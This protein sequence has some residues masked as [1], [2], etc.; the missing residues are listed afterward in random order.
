VTSEAD[1]VESV[2]IDLREGQ[3]RGVVGS[4]H[5]FTP[6]GSFFCPSLEIGHDDEGGLDISFDQAGFTRFVDACFG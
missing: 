2:A 5:F 1:D 4:P 6:G 3:A